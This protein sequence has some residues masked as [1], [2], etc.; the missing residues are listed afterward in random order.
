MNSLLAIFR[1]NPNLTL[2]VAMGVSFVL[3]LTLLGMVLRASG[4]SLRPII[5]MAVLMLPLAV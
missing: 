4:A 3:V 2:A 5:F 1:A